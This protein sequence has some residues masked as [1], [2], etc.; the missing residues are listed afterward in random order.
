MKQKLLLLLLL[1][2]I[3][4]NAQE[5]THIDFDDNNPNIVFNSWNTSSTFAKVANPSQNTSNTSNFVGKFT[6]GSNNGIGIGIIDSPSIFTTPFNIASNAI[7]KMKM[8][9][10][11][12]IEVTFHLENSPDWGNNIEVTTSVAA[13]DINKWTELTFDFSSFSNINMNNIVIIIGGANT[14]EGDI[15]FFDD[16]KG[17][18]L[19]TSPA[20][21]YS[22]VNSATEVVIN[23]N[24]VINTNGNFRELDDSELTDLTAKV[25][26]RIGDVNG[27]DVSFAATINGDK[28]EITINPTSD[29]SNATTYWYGILDNTIEFAT[30]EAVTGA[31]ASF[32]TKAAITG[33]INEML[34]DFDTTNENVGFE[35]W[36]GTG[37]AK[38]AN[39]DA[40]GINVSGN[41]GQ[42]THA[43]NDS[44][45]E[46]SL[47]DNATPLTPFDFAE[48]PF[49][50]VKV[51]VNKP[52]AVTVRLQNYPDYGNGEE[53]VIE[54]T[55]TNTWV[56]LIYSYSSATAANYDRA[57]IYFDR[58]Q[59]AGSVAGDV[60]YFDDY[61]KSN[62]AP[63][64]S[65]TV[66]PANDATEVLQINN[67]M[68]TSNFQFRNLDNSTITDISSFV[69]LREN[70]ASGALVTINAI[71]S[72]DN[73]RITIL[74]SALLEVNATYWYGIVDNVIEY[75]ENDTA[76]TGV[77][78]T[79]TTSAT[80]LNMVTYNDFDG[81]SL[82]TVSE[83][84]GEPAAP[85]TTVVD[86][87]GGS[88]MVKKWE[89]GS[90]WG[91]WER[92]HFQ[93]NAPFDASK[94]GIF[95]FRVYAPVTTNF[96][97]KLAD[98]KGDGDQTSV[99]EKYGDILVANQWQTFYVDASELASGV[100]LDHVFIFLGPGQGNIT[101]TFYIDDVK[102][103]QLQGT[104]S[105]N[106]LEDT[107][108]Q[109]F[110]NPAK[111]MIRF[112][113]LDGKKEIKIFDINSKQ[114]LHKI[115]E[116]N[117]LSIKSLT[118]GFYFLEIN[119]QYKKL[120]KE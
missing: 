17:P 100:S 106:D 39:P 37:F 13:A 34:F 24:L 19:Y 52:V 35:S 98:A 48:T 94:G 102:G 71:L 45:L 10:T 70:D 118:P 56:E 111:D 69:E 15:Y 26:L 11:E 23:T 47:V 115:I 65:T 110:P 104:A 87:I 18:A 112:K 119:G 107:A 95:S 84:M 40:S 41:V 120:I 16:I 64:V 14:S 74:P 49:I 2:F 4:T 25:A 43:G 51:W 86:P 21:E 9:A 68:I 78:A 57:Q 75:K 92:I 90:S 113:N 6:A 42:Y 97:F 85:Y 20:N 8:F 28:N 105:V 59:S 108:F 44:G 73:T 46:N 99:L 5:V 67:P 114:V 77:S 63:E 22:P 32:T 101:G 3:V 58:D 89:K 79:F 103:P 60:Y 61:L 83:T 66:T 54:V 30:D 62:V 80:A 38:I 50:K 27:A 72:D 33:D 29:L 55:E 7:F 109:F 93:L 82:M 91:G 117:E 116:S 81:T 53:K 12:E 1:T 88:N 76:V 36:S 96:M 31:S